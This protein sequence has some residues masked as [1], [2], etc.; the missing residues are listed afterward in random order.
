MTDWHCHLLPGLDD[1]SATVDESVAM[2]QALRDAGFSTVCCTSHLI[3]G[4]YEASNGQVREAVAAMQAQ[5]DVLG[6]ELRLLPGREYYLDEF[7]DEHLQDPL[8]L[9]DTR[10]ILIEIPSHLP[11][12][13]AKETC[14]RISCSGFTPMIAHPERCRLF[15]LPTAAGGKLLEIFN[16]FKTTSNV[17]RRTLNAQSNSLLDYL[18]GLGC[19]FQGNLGSFAGRYGERVRHAAERLREAGVYTHYGSDAHAVEHIQVLKL[20]T[21]IAEESS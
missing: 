1:G 3:K 8:P 12:D 2:A 16:V 19:A 11:A 7:I 10:F 6:I 18:I 17:E 14:Y 20:P 9:G 13:H 21:T 4:C 15:D 5:L